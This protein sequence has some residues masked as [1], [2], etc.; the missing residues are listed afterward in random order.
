MPADK[1]EHIK[2]YNLDRLKV[3]I[4]NDELFWFIQVDIE[5]P[6]HLKKNSVKWHQ[7]FK[8]LKLNLKI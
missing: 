8:I 6:E 1:H 3:D 7:N 5:T 2:T 4:L